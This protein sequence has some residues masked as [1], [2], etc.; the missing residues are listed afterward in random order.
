MRGIGSAADG[1]FIPTNCKKAACARAAAESSSHG[2]LLMLED[3]DVTFAII[4]FGVSVTLSEVLLA[5]FRWRA[6]L[7]T[8]AKLAAPIWAL[9]LGIYLMFRLA[10]AWGTT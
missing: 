2:D 1:P 5:G 8:R 10:I 9:M 6:T 3:A 4:S 7:G